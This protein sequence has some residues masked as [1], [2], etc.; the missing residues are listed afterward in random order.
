[1]T[2][3][4]ARA[5]MQIQIGTI[6]AMMRFDTAQFEV[7]AGDTVELMFTNNCI[8]PHNF[9]MA[10]AG[11]ADMV[12][13][14]ATAL[15]S[16]GFAKDFVAETANVLR[17]TKLIQPGE[18]E[19]LKF[20]APPV[21]GD[22]PYL[23]T[24]PGHGLTMRGVMR[25]KPA[26]EQLAETTRIEPSRVVIADTFANVKYTT[27][28][29]GSVDRPLVMHSF[30]PNPGLP[31]NVFA[32]HHQAFAARRYDPVTGQDR[33][34]T[35]ETIP[36]LATAIG[37]NFG[38]GISLCWDTTECRLMYVWTGGFL[39]MAPY[40][41][42]GAGGSRTANAYVP[43]LVGEVAHLSSGSHPLSSAAT[44]APKYTGYRLEKNIPVFSYKLGTM[45]VSEKFTP[46]PTGLVNVEY[47]IQAGPERIAL[48][49]DGKTRSVIQSTQGRWQQNLLILE[50]ADAHQFTLQILRPAAN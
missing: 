3:M 24:F 25:V 42:R 50:G 12:V 20:S 28:P 32:L 37:V 26:G 11:K 34:G 7:N 18:F 33:D 45:T 47:R 16:D 44:A 48:T 17:H 30:M 41:G 29:L 38:D 21:P 6:K 15:G 39:D 43:K 13:A 22:Y 46:N 36:G 31:T 9:V 2:A 49:F 4:P 5:A 8:M 35:V 10:A 14:E 27:T 19:T 1:M 40:W 23:C